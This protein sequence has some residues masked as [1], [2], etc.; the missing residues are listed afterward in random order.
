MTGR[1]LLAAPLGY[2]IV[3]VLPTGRRVPFGIADDL[4]HAWLVE[5]ALRAAG[6]TRVLVEPVGV[7]A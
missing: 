6:H 1:W 4:P 7:A 2:R 3:A 5:R